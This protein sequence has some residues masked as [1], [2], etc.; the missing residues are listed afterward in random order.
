MAK[1]VLYAPTVT[2]ETVKLLVEPGVEQSIFDM[3][4]AMTGGRAAE[5]LAGY[6]RLLA[7]RQSEIYVLTMVQWQLRNLLL[8][9]AAPS[10]M[11]AAELAREAGMSPYVAGKMLMAARRHS[12][13]ALSAAYRAAAACEY[14]IKSGRLPGEAAVEQ[15][16]LR[17]AGT[18]A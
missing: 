16:I 7:A 6:R 8:A 12:A 3:V 15:L 2:V 11:A 4:E 1:L 10:D 5:A 14:D 17:V 18:S 13:A 9:A